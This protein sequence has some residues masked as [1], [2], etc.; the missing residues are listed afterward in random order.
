MEISTEINTNLLIKKCQRC[1]SKLPLDQFNG[2]KGEVKACLRCRKMSQKRPR[3]RHKCEHGKD[4]YYCFSCHGPGICDHN[5]IKQT[6]VS[7]RG[8]GLCIHNKNRY[9]CTDC[10]ENICIHKKY[11]KTCTDC[12]LLQCEHNIVRY[13]CETCR[14]KELCLHNKI[15]IR[16]SECGN[17]TCDHKKL[18]NICKKCHLLKC[19]HDIIRHL[20]DNCRSQGMCFHNLQRRKCKLC[21]AKLVCIHNK[22]NYKCRICGR[23]TCIHKKDKSVCRA[24]NLLQCDHNMVRH[25][26][27]LCRS[28]GLCIHNKRKQR[29]ST[30]D[31]VGHLKDT[32]RK[33]ILHMLSTNKSKH[34][35]E[36]I[37]CTVEELK[38]HLEHRFQPGMTWDNRKDWHVDHIRPLN[39]E[40]PITH[41]ELIKRFHYTNLQPL[42]AED[43]MKKGNREDPFIVSLYALSAS[44]AKLIAIYKVLQNLS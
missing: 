35:F 8:S 1:K 23:G 3:Y 20:C 15:R 22:N 31:P 2:I 4:P 34:T 9:K 13:L 14:D 16:C 5:R 37:G 44:I 39:P 11:K 38:K 24:C 30:C 12:H 29:C 43:N 28:S 25:L 6:C 27:D 18:K 17:N 19:E 21:N 26:C 42:W 41:E 40:Y 36:Y 7:C 33:R 10:V 32:M